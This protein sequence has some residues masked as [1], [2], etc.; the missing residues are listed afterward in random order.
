MGWVKSLLLLCV[1]QEVNNRVDLCFRSCCEDVQEGD[2]ELGVQ[3]A[4]V[5]VN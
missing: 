1:G 5:V 2:L 4:Q 3:L